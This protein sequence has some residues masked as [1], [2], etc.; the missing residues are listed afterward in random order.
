MKNKI[1]T[2]LCIMAI[3]ITTVI[4]A[5]DEERSSMFSPKIDG[6]VV[7]EGMID[8]KVET[9]MNDSLVLAGNE[10]KLYPIIGEILSTDTTNNAVYGYSYYRA[11]NEN[12]L[13]RIVTVANTSKKDGNTGSDLFV[14]TIFAFESGDMDLA[15]FHEAM[16]LKTNSDDWTW[17]DNTDA[18]GWIPITITDED[19]TANYYMVV[20]TYRTPLS[21][22]GIT[23]PSLLQ[24]GLESIVESDVAAQFSDKYKMY[25]YSQ[26]TPVDNWDGIEYEDAGM[27]IPELGSI[28]GVLDSAFG[29]ITSTNHPWDNN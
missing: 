29:T 23:E 22:D 2:L 28:K 11:S 8:Q 3:L 6:A 18:S 5:A 4:V 24:I 13:D 7:S 26:A 20:A 19:G 1:V 21:V 12:M 14:R 25:V 9:F 16:Y 10:D 27:T 15:E 17:P